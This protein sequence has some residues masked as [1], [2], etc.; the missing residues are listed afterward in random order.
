MGNGRRG[1]SL[2]KLGKVIFGH[3]AGVMDADG[4]GAAVAG[5]RGVNKYAQR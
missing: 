1:A 4:H 3:G 2:D 5:I